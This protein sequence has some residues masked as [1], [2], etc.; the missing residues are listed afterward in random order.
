MVLEAEKIHQEWDQPGQHGRMTP[1]AKAHRRN[2]R[3]ESSWF[4][5]AQEFEELFWIEI[6]GVSSLDSLQQAEKILETAKQAERRNS[7]GGEVLEEYENTEVPQMMGSPRSTRL[8][9]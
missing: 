4:R 9:R 8:G 1:E 6:H 3:C 7:A 2:T 5:F